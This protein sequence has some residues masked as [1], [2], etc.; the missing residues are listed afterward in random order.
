[1]GCMPIRARQLLT[2]ALLALMLAT[3][4]SP[5]LGWGMVASHDTLA[6]GISAVERVD[7][8]HDHDHHQP[9]IPDDTHDHQD[10][11]TSIGHLLSHMPASLF[12]VPRFGVVPTGNSAI[13]FLYQPVLQLNPEPPLRPPKAPLPH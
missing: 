6:H 7:L 8:H 9:S 5:T 12:E 4:L 11:H 13:A 10:A 3:F 1:M 2:H